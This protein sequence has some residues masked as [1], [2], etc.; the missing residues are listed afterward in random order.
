MVD[1]RV[2]DAIIAKFT[3]HVLRDILLS[4]EL[5]EIERAHLITAI[6]YLE[7]NDNV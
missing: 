6:Y 1:P 7:E 3:A 2:V 5:T 4:W